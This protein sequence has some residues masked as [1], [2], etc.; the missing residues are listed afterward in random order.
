MSIPA[1]VLETAAAYRRGLIPALAQVGFEVDAE[2]DVKGRHLVLAPLRSPGDCAIYEG[3]AGESDAVVVALIDAADHEAYAH[4]L[5]HGAAGA[6]AWD[7]DPEH[8]ASVARAAVDGVVMLPIEAAVTMA[9]RVTDFHRDRPLLDPT[10]VAW[11]VELSRGS[12][13][14]AL[15]ERYGYSERVMFRRL[16]EVYARLGAMNRAEALV[17]A[18]RF[19]LLEDSARGN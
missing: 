15:A 5:S 6:V 7:A 4:A 18:E 12:T 19:G 3:F 17:A 1:V 10:E 13:V 9:R 16:G 8:I 11:I 2:R 14:V